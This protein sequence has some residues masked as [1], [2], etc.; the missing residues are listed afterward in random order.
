[1][2]LAILIYV[3]GAVLVYVRGVEQKPWIGQGIRF[4][5]LFGSSGRRIQFAQR[6]GHLANVVHVGGELDSQREF[7]IRS[8]WLGG[9]G[10]L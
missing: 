9:G 6:V 3:F 4:G 5:I 8:V 7:A 10:N 2:L 1:M